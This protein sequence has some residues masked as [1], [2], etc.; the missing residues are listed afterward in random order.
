MSLGYFGMFEVEFLPFKGGWAAID[1]NPRLYNQVGLDISRGLPLPL[2]ACL[3]A[4]GE[5]SELRDAVA[6]AQF[7][8]DDSTMVLYDRF[9]LHALLAA[10]YMTS[11]LSY[12]D[13]RYWKDWSKRSGTR[14]IDVA[15]DKEDMMPGIIHALS[16]IY[17]GTKAIQRFFKSNPRVNSA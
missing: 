6:R 1:F 2:L 15:V 10:M 12:K 4:L 5:A 14:V 7:V 3:G 8:T 13:L 16:E 11:R 9:T 17:L